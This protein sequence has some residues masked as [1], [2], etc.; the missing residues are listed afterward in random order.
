[1]IHPNR[2]PFFD[3]E[4]KELLGFL[5]QDAAGWQAQTVFGYTIARTLS[6]DDAKR[7]LRDQGLSILKGVWQYYD[8]DDHQWHPCILRETQE[9]RVT[10]IRTNTMGYQD[11]ETYKMYTIKDPSDHTLVKA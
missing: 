3:V 4:T 5:L 8:G 7:V 10:V 9:H 1:M 2:T 11:P 6:E